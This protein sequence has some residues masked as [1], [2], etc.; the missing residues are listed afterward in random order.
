[1]KKIKKKKTDTHYYMITFMHCFIVRETHN[2]QFLWRSILHKQICFLPARPFF[3]SESFPKF[4]FFF[5]VSASNKINAVIRTKKKTRVA[6][7]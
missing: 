1:M 4:F 3:L 2:T 5:N 7:F 6:N